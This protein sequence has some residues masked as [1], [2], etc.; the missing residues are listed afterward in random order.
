MLG[1]SVQ[2]IPPE[3]VDGNTPRRN[4][5]TVAIGGVPGVHSVSSVI[6]PDAPS[7]AP[8]AVTSIVRGIV[9]A[10]QPVHVWDSR[11]H[12]TAFGNGTD[13]VVIAF[14]PGSKG[15]SFV[16]CFL[17]GSSTM[18]CP[19]GQVIIYLSCTEQS[20]PCRDPEQLLRPYVTALLHSRGNDS[21]ALPLF[22]LYYR[23]CLTPCDGR[24]NLPVPRGSGWFAVDES[25]PAVAALTETGDTLASRATTLF[26]EVSAYI[27]GDAGTQL[28]EHMWPMG[29][30]AVSDTATRGKP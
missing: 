11:G 4:G 6:C 14:D 30:P 29:G 24:L 12:E 5:F 2:F 22:E 20:T 28:S 16:T 19:K 25:P 3:P 13:N 23:E 18:S 8:P 15:E 26:R 27:S 17:T 9:I 7:G 21:F 10:N 1:C